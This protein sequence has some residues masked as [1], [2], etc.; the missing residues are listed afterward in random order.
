MSIEMTEEGI[1]MCDG[2]PC[3]CF[4]DGSKQCAGCPLTES[5]S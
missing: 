5:I 2:I 4:Q 3:G 1:I